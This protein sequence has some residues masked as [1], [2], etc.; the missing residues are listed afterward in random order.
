MS[1]NRTNVEASL[2]VYQGCKLREQHNVRCKK[3]SFWDRFQKRLAFRLWHIFLFLF[4]VATI[5]LLL[6]LL[7][8]GVLRR[9]ETA[10]TNGRKY[11][12][13]SNEVQYKASLNMCKE[14]I[15]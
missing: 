1:E 14:E 10:V 9:K 13:K 7:S 12:K 2:T 11:N 6:G 3:N 8:P 15:N 5:I 4:V